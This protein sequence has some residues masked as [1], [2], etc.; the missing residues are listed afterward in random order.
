MAVV[1]HGRCR[2]GED[3]IQSEQ[4]RRR[5]QEV[6]PVQRWLGFQRQISLWELRPEAEAG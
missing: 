4:S 6:A 3:S 2:S 5:P 1:G